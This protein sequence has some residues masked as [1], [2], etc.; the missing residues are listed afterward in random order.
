MGTLQ[1]LAADTKS[2]PDLIKDIVELI[3][4]EVASKR[5]PTGFA[6][7]AGYKVVSK[8]RGGQMIP[9]G[10]DILLDDFSAALDPFVAEYGE[11]EPRGFA[12]YLLERE[13]AVA[14]ALL[15]VADG[16]V[17]DTRPLIQNTYAKL[18]PM[19]TKQVRD[20]VPAL[21][22]LIEGYLVDAA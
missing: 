15:N 12:A 6:L 16:R 11:R 13:D 7:K 4:R 18:R 9:R 21:G 19:A 20:A 3:D 5:G 10:V 22:K 8:L 2:R 14:Q 17:R 1:E